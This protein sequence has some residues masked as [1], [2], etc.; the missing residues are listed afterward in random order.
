MTRLFLPLRAFIPLGSSITSQQP[1]NPPA[2][3]FD[4]TIGRVRFVIVFEKT[5]HSMGWVAR[6]GG[7]KFIF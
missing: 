7:R 2:G 1:L 3:E 4:E 5:R 6:A